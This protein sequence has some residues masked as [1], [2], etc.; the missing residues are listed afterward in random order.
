M[1]NFCF[2][3]KKFCTLS[4]IATFL[5]ISLIILSVTLL[6]HLYQDYRIT[7]LKSEKEYLQ[8][9][10][11]TI[12]SRVVTLG[13]QLSRI[14]NQSDAL[15][16]AVNLEPIDKDVRK[17]GFGGPSFYR[18]LDMGYIPEGIDNTVAV[19]ER[20]LMQFEQAVKLE[21]HNLEELVAKINDDETRRDHWPSIRPILGGSITDNFGWRIDPL[22]KKNAHHNGVDIPMPVGTPILA[23]GGGVV[24]E[25]RNSYIKNQDYGKQIIINHGYGLQTRYAHC[26]NILVRPGDQVK[27]WDPIAEV[28]ATGRVTGPHLHYEVMENTKC[29]DPE[30]Y[31]FN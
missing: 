18:M 5:F 29:V 8:S 12:Q 23:T 13:E 31:I 30:I 21:N 25:V 11:L 27:K 24:A 17:L 9:E 1:K 26:S 6:N 28:G 3:W 15:R 16:N 14:E 22:T 7:S 4:A 10:L 2:S 19:I 20:D